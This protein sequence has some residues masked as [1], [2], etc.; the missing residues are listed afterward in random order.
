MTQTT[1]PARGPALAA[2]LRREAGILLRIALPLWAGYVAEVVMWYTDMAVVGRIGS[3]E[4]AAVGLAGDVLFELLFILMGLVSIAGVLVAQALGA[5]SIKDAAAGVRQGLLVGCAVAVPVTALCWGLAD[6]LSLT[7]QD[8]RVIA[9]AREY[10]A[11]V[12]WSVLPLIAFSVLRSFMAALART[13][14]VMAITVA[15]ALVKPGLT[16]VLVFGWAGVPGLGVA[17]AGLATSAACWAMALAL[18]LAIHRAPDLAAYRVFEGPWRIDLKVWREIFRLGVPVAGMTAVEGAMFVVVAVLAGRLG[19]DVL[20]A[21][22]IVLNWMTLAFVAAIALGEAAMVRVAFAMG[23]GNPGRA[24][25]VGWLGG[26]ITLAAMTI[27]GAIGILA[28]GVI[29]AIF[30]DA[31]GEANIAVLALTAEL[32]AIAALF[33]LFDGLQAVMARALRGLKDTLAPLWIAAAGYW[34]LGIPGGYLLA[35]PLGLG[36]AGLWW[37]L[38]IGLVVAGLLLAVRFEQHTR[39]LIAAR[40]GLG[41]GR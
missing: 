28:P 3:G 9:I 35:F 41:P 6:L 13:R 11:V 2:S 20:A 34:V 23:Q 27:G 32:L 8:P 38:A 12:S 4:L 37:G 10:M 17:G 22:Q 39:V 18:A 40:R 21:C 7:G 24:R 14:V 36:S 29:G 26:A 19:A 1:A 5:S 15:V 16:Y 33:Q 31:E 30:L 25:T